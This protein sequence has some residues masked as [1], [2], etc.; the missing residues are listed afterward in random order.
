[1]I[2]YQQEK[3]KREVKSAIFAVTDVSELFERLNAPVIPREIPKYDPPFVG[4]TCEVFFVKEHSP[5]KREEGACTE[6]DEVY[7]RKER[8]GGSESGQPWDAKVRE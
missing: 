5:E 2:R 6:K 4:V 8:K 7:L 3:K 1:M